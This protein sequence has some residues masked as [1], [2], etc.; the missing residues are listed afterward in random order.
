[1]K[2]NDRPIFRGSN[3]DTNKSESVRV[4]ITRTKQRTDRKRLRDVVKNYICGKNCAHAIGSNNITEHLMV[5]TEVEE[6]KVKALL[7]LECM[8]NYINP[9]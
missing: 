9:K 7:D 1:M 2:I 8:R 6:V 5:I 4:S 3:A